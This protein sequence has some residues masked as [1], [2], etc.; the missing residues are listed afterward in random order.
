MKICKQYCGLSLQSQIRRMA[1]IALIA[2]A[3][4]FPASASLGGDMTTV[5][6]DQMHMQGTLRSTNTQAYTVHEIHAPNGVAVREF[7]SPA[8][9]VFGVAWQGPAHP[10]LQQVLGT[11][12]D[13]FTQAVQAERAR[14]S[15]HGPLLIQTPGLVVQLGGHMRAFAGRVYVPQM[16]PAGVRAEEIR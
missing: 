15:G 7:V 16:M 5:Q 10:D 8:G 13:Q 6:A 1:G 14:H 3:L 2:L 9:K 11:Y 4:S 12:F